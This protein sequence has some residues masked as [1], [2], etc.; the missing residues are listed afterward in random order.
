MAH[1]ESHL[2][3]RELDGANNALIALVRLLARQA[4]AE[5]IATKDEKPVVPGQAETRK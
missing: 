1:S 3:N 2:E 4:A 5:A